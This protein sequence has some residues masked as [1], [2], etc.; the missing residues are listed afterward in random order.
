[1]SREKKYILIGGLILLM[2]GAT[3]RFWP[4]IEAFRPLGE[5][6]AFK[7]RKVDKYRQMV[8]KRN[9]LDAEILSLN[10]D[11]ERAASGLLTGETTALVAV[12]IQNILNDIASRSEVEVKTMRVLNPKDPEEWPPGKDRFRVIPVQ[13]S[14]DANIRQLKE[15]LYKIE[16]SRKFLR[17]SDMRIRVNNIKKTEQVY[18]TLTVEGF[19]RKREDK[20]KE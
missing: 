1:M 2:A 9:A 7:E 12:D 11:L 5:A 13:I 19:M 10:R 17:I 15:I 14:M 18:S 3:Y 16:T 6:M 20:G 8:Q 4:E